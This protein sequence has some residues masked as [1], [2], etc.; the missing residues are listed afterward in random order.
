MADITGRKVTNRPL[1]KPPM[2]GRIIELVMGGATDREI[3]SSISTSQRQFSF[4]A[5]AAFRQRHAKQINAAKG[6]MLEA[7]VKY[8]I[9][10]KDARL[11]DLQMLRDRTIAL[12]ESRQGLEARDYKFGPEGERIL[13]LRYDAGMVTQ[14]RGILRDAA[15]ELGQI[16]KP[17]VTNN[18]QVNQ[19]LIRQYDVDTPELT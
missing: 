6:R 11:A 13:I 14:L 18:V 1:D 2:K 15:E 19:Y 9:A 8:T 7:A 12:I 16:E 3:A 17:A 10:S 4:Q 5:I